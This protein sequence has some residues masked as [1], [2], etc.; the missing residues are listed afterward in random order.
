MSEKQRPTSPHLQIYKWNISSLTSIAH[1]LTGVLL[2]AAIL[3]ISWY[4]VY[5]AYKLGATDPMLEQMEEECDCP[6]K[7]LI[8]F[9]FSGALVVVIF[10]LYYHF[11]NGIRHL[12]WDFGKGFEKNTAKRTGLL[13][14]GLTLLFTIITVLI[15]VFA[16]PTEVNEIIQ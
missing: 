1:R 2:Y 13:V 3:V 11:F 7:T 4:V 8:R 15:V 12:F 16:T 6:L 5:Y 10:S 14:L 9:I